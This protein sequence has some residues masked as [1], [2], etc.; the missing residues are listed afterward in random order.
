M[1]K[2]KTDVI[3]AT[4][5]VDRECG[6]GF[7]KVILQE[8]KDHSCLCRIAGRLIKLKIGILAG[9]RVSVE[10][11]PYDLTRGRIVLRERKT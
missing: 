11:S 5:V 9:D 1:P 7:F 4:G 8:P 10:L 6:N 3:Q 2:D